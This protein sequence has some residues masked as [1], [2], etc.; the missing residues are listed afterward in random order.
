MLIKMKTRNRARTL[1]SWPHSKA[2][3]FVLFPQ[4]IPAVTIISYFLDSTHS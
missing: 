1:F 3:N 4:I 2:G